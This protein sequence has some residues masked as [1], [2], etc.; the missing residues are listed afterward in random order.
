MKRT[1]TLLDALLSSMN[2][3]RI[4]LT[5]TRLTFSEA[6]EAVSASEPQIDMVAT[7][8]RKPSVKNCWIPYYHGDGS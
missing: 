1:L 6:G 5:A 8:A 2:S 7:Y 4:C 3:I